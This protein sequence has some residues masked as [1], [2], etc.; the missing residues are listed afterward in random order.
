M[1]QVIC[2][3][4]FCYGHGCEYA[5]G[6]SFS[7]NLC[8]PVSGI[9][10]LEKLEKFMCLLPDIVFLTSPFKAILICRENI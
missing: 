3:F 9:S 10:Y 1:A 4:F 5:L 7:S 8:V 2:R 6:L